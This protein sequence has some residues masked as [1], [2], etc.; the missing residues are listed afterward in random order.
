MQIRTAYIKRVVSYLVSALRA[1]GPVGFNCGPWESG[2]NSLEHAVVSTAR[3]AQK[4]RSA[5]VK[6]VFNAGDRFDSASRRMDPSLVSHVCQMMFAPVTT[7]PDQPGL[8]SEGMRF[9]CDH[10]LV[11]LRSLAMVAFVV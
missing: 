3:T 4:Q 1:L 2:S 9:A 11:T 6:T 5:F 8:V 10:P 7:I